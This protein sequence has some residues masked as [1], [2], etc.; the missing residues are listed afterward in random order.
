MQDMRSCTDTTVIQV[1][2]VCMGD[3]LSLSYTFPQVVE[4]QQSTEAH[5]KCQ[6]ESFT[7]FKVTHLCSFIFEHILLIT[8]AEVNV[9]FI[10]ILSFVIVKKVLLGKMLIPTKAGQMLPVFSSLL[11]MGQL[12]IGMVCILLLA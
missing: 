4:R 2:G 10:L 11:N 7:H 9:K 8:I 1:L 6:I 12:L 3:R 5:L